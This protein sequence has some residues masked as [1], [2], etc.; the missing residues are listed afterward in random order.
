MKQ[1]RTCVRGGDRTARARGMEQFWSSASIVLS[2]LQSSL[3]HQKKIMKT[4]QRGRKGTTKQNPFHLNPS[5]LSLSLFLNN[6]NNNKV[7]H[8]EKIK[9]NFMLKNSVYFDFS[10]VL[11]KQHI[12]PSLLCTLK[13]TIA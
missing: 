5:L 12:F 10:W 1:G 8:V 13:F 9:M 11:L 7:M 3:S 4:D 2:S 6:N